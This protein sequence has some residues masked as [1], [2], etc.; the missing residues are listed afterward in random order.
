M[1][2]CTKSSY[3]LCDC[4]GIAEV[5]F[6]HSSLEQPL[7]YNQDQKPLMNQGSK[8]PRTKFLGSDGFLCFGS[9]CKFGSFKNP[10]TA[11][12]GLPELYFRLG[13]SA[14]NEVQVEL[15]PAMQG[16]L[17]AEIIETSHKSRV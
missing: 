13:T 14:E 1:F 4:D 9:I 11:I 16:G 7:E 8:V 3:Q 15:S 12:T 17:H 5:L 6:D 2:K 10:F